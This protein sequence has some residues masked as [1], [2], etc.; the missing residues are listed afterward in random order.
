MPKKTKKE[1]ARNLP[2]IEL[3]Q[4]TKNTIWGIVFFVFGLFFILA[5]FNY[6]GPAG[7]HSY[8]FLSNL[9][10][11]GFILIPATFIILSLSAWQAISTHFLTQRIIGGGALFL[12]SLGTLAVI[13]NQIQNQ[14]ISGGVIGGW[15]TAPLLMLF[16]FY[17]TLLLLLAIMVIS[18]LVIFDTHIGLGNLLSRW[19]VKQPKVGSETNQEEKPEEDDEPVLLEEQEEAVE[20]KEP[21]KKGRTK[22][23]E[24]ESETK[25][26]ILSAMPFFSGRSSTESF[27]PP[28]VA[29]LSK[30]SGKPGAGNIKANSN[31]IK[32]TL[33]NFGI[34]VEM[35]EVT[36]GPSITRYALKPAEGVKVSRILGLQ[37]D[38]SLALAAH[39]IRIEAP[40]PGKPLVG[41]EIPNNVKTTVGLGSMLSS[42]EF[43]ENPNPLLLSLGRGI[44]GQMHF[45]NLAKAPHLL[46]AGATGSGKSVMIHSAILSLLY[47]NPPDNLRMIMVDPKRVELT[48]YKNTPHLLTPVITNAKKAITALR[49]A[50]EEMD[51]RYDILEKEAVRDISSYHKNIV[52]PALAKQAKQRKKESS[53]EEE[54]GDDIERMPYIV[55]IIDELADIMSSYPRELEAAIVR[56]AQMSRA[57]GIHLLVSTQRPSVEVITGLIKANIPARIALQVAS[58]IDSRTILD[59]PG[60]EKLL[61]AG[62][63]LFLSGEMS[64]PTRLQSTM[65][66]E[67][68]VK[69]VV[70][71]LKNQYADQLSEE[72]SL[73]EEEEK[74]RLYQ[75]QVDDNEEDALYE[76]ARE[77]VIKA[78]KASASY[79]QRK[80]KVGYARA[81]RLLDMLEE[82]GVIGP[83][84][85]AKPRDIYEKPPSETE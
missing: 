73:S 27:T 34:Q 23:D 83:G 57:V 50:A 16:D 56:L 33:A 58:Q 61:G 71:H 15:L 21:P 51:R 65:V 75:G 4:E 5:R 46:I 68:E 8:N 77:A 35:D 82:R 13:S 25:A 19:W 30:D 11:S 10:G 41:I 62:D 26:S 14:V 39:P 76:D 74:D 17:I 72:L 79:L 7:E 66:T 63:M 18:I 40:I 81:A 20:E 42:K 53:E 1:P 47:K 12:S 9:F 6:A 2:K 84:E 67:E 54:I 37:N 80:L 69:K 44:S 31:I 60:A 49:W 64:K 70:N 55:I 29:L 32:R 78:Q 3:K 48:L 28:P 36:V 45:A 24:D 43:T 59:M 22:T 85:G 52:E 38:L